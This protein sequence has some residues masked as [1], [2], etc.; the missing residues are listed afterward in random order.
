MPSDR[1]HVQ[2]LPLRITPTLHATI[3]PAARRRHRPRPPDC[4][5]IF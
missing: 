2:Q 3:I 1:L 4:P 5:A